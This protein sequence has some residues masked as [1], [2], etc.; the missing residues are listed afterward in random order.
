MN[1]II[2]EE[3]P[4][5]EIRLPCGNYFSTVDEAKNS[6]GLSENHIWSV[7]EDDGVFSYGPCNHYVNLLGYTVTRESHDENTYY[8][9]DTKLD[10]EDE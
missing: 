5:E 6:T 3:F 8:I 9:E 1:I 2:E 10:M 4:F 7:T